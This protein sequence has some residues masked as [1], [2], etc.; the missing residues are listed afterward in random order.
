MYQKEISEC[1]NVTVKKSEEQLLSSSTRGRH[2]SMLLE[3]WGLVPRPSATALPQYKLVC[4]Y[5]SVLCQA[6]Q[7]ELGN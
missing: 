1:R 5:S 4:L 3:L 7:V 6:A 2:K